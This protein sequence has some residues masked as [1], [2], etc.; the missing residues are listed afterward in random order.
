[1]YPIFKMMMATSLCV[2]LAAFNSTAE[3]CSCAAPD[4]EVSFDQSTD[5]AIVQI[6]SKHRRG[7]TLWMVASVKKTFKGCTESSERILLKTAVSSATCGLTNLKVGGRYLINGDQGDSVRGMDVLQVGLCDYNVPVK[8]LTLSDRS[9]LGKNAESCDEMTC[10]DL[11]D[12]DFGNCEMVL[13]VGVIDG[14]CATIS[15]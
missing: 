7:N 10:D 2:G 4:I 12:E 11:A 14:E 13:G 6:G 9:F 8:N 1:M 3:A 5:V 15:G